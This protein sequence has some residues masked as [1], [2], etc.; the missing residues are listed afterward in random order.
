MASDSI[1]GAEETRDFHNPLQTEEDMAREWVG[2]NHPELDGEE[3]NRKVRAVAFEFYLDTLDPIERRKIEA[4][5]AAAEEFDETQYWL[6][7]QLG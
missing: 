7:L 4:E 2:E 6:C 5:I 1:L 3:F